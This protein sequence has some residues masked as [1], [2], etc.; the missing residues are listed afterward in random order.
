MPRYEHQCRKCSFSWEETYKSDEP[1][2]DSCPD[3][4]AKEV[5]RCVSAPAFHLKGPGWALD[6]YS[7]MANIQSLK[8]RLKIYDHHEDYFRESVGEAKEKKKRMLMK[9]NEVIKRT[10][11]PDAVIKEKEANV[12][13]DKAAKKAR[14]M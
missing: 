2:P 5:F 11:G 10:L 1:I 13:I 6:G 7:K 12:K 9:Q 3:C 8:G 14:E 4:G